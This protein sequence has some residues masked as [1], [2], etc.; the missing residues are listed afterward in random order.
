MGQYDEN[1]EFENAVI[2]NGKYLN[3]GME[4]KHLLIL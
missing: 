4:V 2:E 1:I 3:R